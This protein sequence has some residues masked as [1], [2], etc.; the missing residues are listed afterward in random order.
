[1]HRVK[2]ISCLAAAVLSLLVCPAAW[3]NFAPRFWGDVTSEP[4]G[5]K[6]VAIVHE[7]LT[8]DLRPLLG[9][10][11]VRVEV[12]YELKNAGAS[13]RLELLFV[14]GEVGVSDFDARIDDKPLQ[15]RI[16]P[17]DEARHLW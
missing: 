1:M 4:W 13:K 12:S 14:S 6:E 7:Q 8:I 16:L 9:G 15:T 2:L 10:D 5:V 3:A 11:P 17:S